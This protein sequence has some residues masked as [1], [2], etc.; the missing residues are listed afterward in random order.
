MATVKESNVHCQVFK[1]RTILA[2]D[3]MGGKEE[4]GGEVV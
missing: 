1:L 3:G 4:S 2:G